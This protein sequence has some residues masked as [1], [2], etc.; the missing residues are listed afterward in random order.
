MA[1]LIRCRASIILERLHVACLRPLAVVEFYIC[2]FFVIVHGAR[3]IAICR[4]SV[5]CSCAADA[6]CLLV[7]VVAVWP[8]K[9][10]SLQYQLVLERR[11]YSAFQIT[12]HTQFVLRAGITTLHL[13]GKVRRIGILYP[14]RVLTVPYGTVTAADSTLLS[15]D[16]F[17]RSQPSLS[18]YR[19]SHISPN[20]LPAGA[21]HLHSSSEMNITGYASFENNSA[22]NT[23]GEHC[24]TSVSVV[25]QRL[26]IS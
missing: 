17:R 12:L 7:A 5:Y 16:C 6:G 11:C 4:F 15:I 3:R 18:L 23:G 21:L 13:M 20:P 10:T 26:F 1:Y 19:L 24:H 9:K 8:V 14:T 2:L 25:C 22:L